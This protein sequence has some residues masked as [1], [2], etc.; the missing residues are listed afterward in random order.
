MSPHSAMLHYCTHGSASL[1]AVSHLPKAGWVQA[2][3]VRIDATWG[4]GE[5]VAGGR[6]SAW[7]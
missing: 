6:Y 7:Q 3:D 1:E 4:Q 5:L 2:C